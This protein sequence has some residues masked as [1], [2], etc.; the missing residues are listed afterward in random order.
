MPKNEARM[1][2]EAVTQEPTRTRRTINA[3]EENE[4]KEDGAR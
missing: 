2:Q 4:R 3:N 1:P